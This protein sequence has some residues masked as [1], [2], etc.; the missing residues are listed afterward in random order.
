MERS[1]LWAMRCRHEAQFW[2]HN[3]FV[4]LTY[5][6]EHLPWHGSLNREHLQKFLKRFRKATEG[7]AL[8]PNSKHRPVRFFGCG[9][10]GSTTKR[11]HYH[12]L[13]FNVSIPDR[14]KYGKDTYTSRMLSDLWPYGS[15]LVG[16]VTPASAAYVAGYS[17]KK[18]Y[19]RFNSN[20]EAHYGV[21]NR[22]TGEYV[23]RLPEFSAM[24]LKPGIGQYWYDRY[25]R[26]LQHGYVVLD[27][28]KAPVPRF[29]EQKYRNDFP[30]EIE[31]REFSRE[32]LR[33][34]R[35]PNELSEPRLLAKEAVARSRKAF[36]K[37]D[38]PEI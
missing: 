38:H 20:K 7:V 28:A 13:L 17:M 29:Y 18:V 25:K 31:E 8:A 27:G 15:H 5:D 4:T 32:L 16:T 10:Y 6:D 12:L 1:Q 2:D 30:E 19:G 11:A 35:D 3:A 26:D 23:E 9:E 34:E 36:F 22:E 33:R 21:V 24:S 14:E 37:P